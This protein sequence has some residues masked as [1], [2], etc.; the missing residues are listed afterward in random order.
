MGNLDAKEDLPYQD[1]RNIRESNPEQEDQDVHSA[2]EP[3]YR[4]RSYLVK[5][6]R[7]EGRVS[8]FLSRSVQISGTR[9]ILRGV[10]L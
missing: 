2:M 1:F 3:P 9:F 10:S 5:R 4:G 8:K 7:V 6:R